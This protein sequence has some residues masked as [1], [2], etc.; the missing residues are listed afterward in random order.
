MLRGSAFQ[1]FGPATENALSPYLPTLIG[2]S[3]FLDHSLFNG[4]TRSPN[5][6]GAMPIAHLCIIKRILKAILSFTCSQC[7]SL[8][9]ILHIIIIILYIIY[10]IYMYY[11]YFYTLS[12][13]MFTR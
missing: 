10:Y 2:I 8:N 6:V 1:G 5:S 9:I 12:Y 7:K 3:N 13:F 11:I 4:L